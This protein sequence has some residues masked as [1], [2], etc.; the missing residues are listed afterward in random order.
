MD[1]ECASRRYRLLRISPESYLGLF[2]D[3]REGVQLRLVEG[4]P[5]D[6]RVVNATV[7]AERNTIVLCLESVSY[8]PVPEGCFIPEQY[9]AIERVWPGIVEATGQLSAEDAERIKAHW[10]EE[11]P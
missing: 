2:R 4:P 10:R 5:E 11:Y 9:A 8:D 7:D 6:A 1:A 3:L